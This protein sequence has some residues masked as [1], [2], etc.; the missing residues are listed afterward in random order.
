MEQKQVIAF[1]E[2]QQGYLAKSNGEQLWMHHYT[3][4]SIFKKISGYIPSLDESD[5]KVLEIACLTH[6]LEKRKD[7]YQKMFQE[8]GGRV[9]EGHKP[10]LEGLKNYIKGSNIAKIISDQEIKT[11]YE[12]SLTH[13]SISNK[14]LEEIETPSAGVKTMILTWCDHLASMEEINFS[15]IQRIREKLEGLTDLTYIEISRFPSPTTSLLLDECIKRYRK[16][17]WDLLLVLG[18]GAVFIGKDCKLPEK[19]ILCKEINDKFLSDSLSLQSASVADHTRPFLSGISEVI[20]S[21]FIEI[22]KNEIVNSLGYVDTKEV[23]FLRTLK[24]LFEL[25]GDINKIK[26]ENNRWELLAGC[27]GRSGATRVRDKLW[28]EVLGE[29]PPEKLGSKSINYLF[30]KIS[31]SEIIPPPYHKEVFKGKKLTEL[32]SEELFT[33]LSEIAKD[34]EKK[35]FKPNELIEYIDHLLVVEEGKDF[36]AIASIIFERYKEYKKTSDVSKG[37]CERCCS[38][39]TIYARAQLNFLAG[40]SKSFTQ[41]KPDPT[42]ENATCL[43]CTYDNLIA[44][45]EIKSGRSNIYVSLESK[46]PSYA[47]KEMR[48]MIDALS[49]GLFN[50]YVITKLTEIEAFNDLMVPKRRVFILLPRKFGES[51]GR[52]EIVKETERGVLFRIGWIPT[53]DFSPKDLRAKYAPMYHILNLL[54]YRVSIGT[55]E[56]TGLFGETLLTAENEYYHSLAIVILATVLPDNKKKKYIFAKT[57]LESSPSVAIKLTSETDDGRLRLREELTGSFF[58]F[59]KR[60]K[61]P[62]FKDSKGEYTMKTLLNDAMFFANGIPKFCWTNE[63]YKSWGQNSSK[64]IITKPV[65]RALDEILQ[66]NDFEMA[67]AKFLSFIRE[68][69]SAD[70]EKSEMATTDVKELKEF[71][72][73]SK[74][75]LKRYYDLRNQDITKFI[76][77]KNALMSSIFVFKRY[78]NLGGVLNG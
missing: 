34:V 4:Y 58:K 26:K 49:S 41:I 19:D 24:D 31:Y 28:L 55:E 1:L 15:T 75:I 43:F 45:G 63:E 66:G 30:T 38:P 9:Q 18:N 48:R 36:R 42:K 10:D 53:S 32:K 62:L 6:D 23:L 37:V 72:E 52:T 46:I 17:G 71:V 54:G 25:N 12:Y 7:S 27:L 29:D 76:R 8:G 51:A 3:V 44:R 40:K 56:Q 39:I 5:K 35:T 14:N 33:I 78:P 70:K 68:N 13:H 69:I 67:F 2:L 74:E 50:P 57:L 47:N 60:E 65:S 20:P 59:L 64:H 16:Y 61:K 77:V 73:K 11:T 21:Q 22:K